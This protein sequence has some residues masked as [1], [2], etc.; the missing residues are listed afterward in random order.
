VTTT[1][2]SLVAIV[3]TVDLMQSEFDLVA[4]TLTQA[5]YDL[6]NLLESYVL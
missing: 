3:I 2:L 6:A 4:T 1:L 5:Q